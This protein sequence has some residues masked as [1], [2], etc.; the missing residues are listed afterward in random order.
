MIIFFVGYGSA[1]NFVFPE[2]A[3]SVSKEQLSSTWTSLV[4][5]PTNLNPLSAFSSQIQSS[6]YSNIGSGANGYYIINSNNSTVDAYAI[7][8]LMTDGNSQKEGNVADVFSQGLNFDMSGQ[9]VYNEF[10]TILGYPT[11][12]YGYENEDQ[13]PATV[14]NYNVIKAL[15]NN[16]LGVVGDDGEIMI[17]DKNSNNS[18]NTQ[19]HSTSYVLQ[20]SD[21]MS[22]NHHPSIV[23]YNGADPTFISNGHELQGQNND[24]LLQDEYGEYL[25]DEYGNLL[26]QQFIYDPNNPSQQFV[27]DD[28]GSQYNNV[29]YSDGGRCEQQS[30]LQNSSG[31][32]QEQVYYEMVDQDNFID[33][34]TAAASNSYPTENESHF[35]SAEYG[36]VDLDQELVEATH[37]AQQPYIE[38]KGVNVVPNQ[39]EKIILSSTNK[40]GTKYVISSQVIPASESSSRIN[41]V[42][43][44]KFLTEGFLSVIR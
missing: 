32:G 22:G 19:H 10:D 12:S 25:Y 35:G 40:G 3:S 24:L 33:P 43:N 7:D 38:W 5:V 9:Q 6:T 34:A 1:Q 27:N 11:Q 36:M 8:K 39:G 14:H 2:C 4:P 23:H 15:G 31:K 37:Q 20:G 17:I 18:S 21:P 30:F 44:A 29:V 26:D 41:S 42:S 28:I 16:H 13:K